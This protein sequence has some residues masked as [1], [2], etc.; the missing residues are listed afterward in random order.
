VKNNILYYLVVSMIVVILSFFIWAIGDAI[1]VEKEYRDKIVY[2]H[3]KPYQITNA[4]N[5]GGGI[6][7]TLKSIDNGVEVD[8]IPIDDVTFKGE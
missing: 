1:Q 6:R 4:W 3:D 2:F 7:F 8:T 5:G